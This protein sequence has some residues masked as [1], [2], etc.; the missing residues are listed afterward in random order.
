MLPLSPLITSFFVSLIP[1]FRAPAA[2]QQF[3]NSKKHSKVFINT[4]MNSLINKQLQTDEKKQ[5][6][7]VCI[8]CIFLVTSIHIN[9]LSDWTDFMHAAHTE[10]I[11]ILIDPSAPLATLWVCLFSSLSGPIR[12]KKLPLLCCVYLLAG[13]GILK[14][15]RDSFCFEIHEAGWLDKY[16]PHIDIREWPRLPALR[17]LTDIHA[18]PQ[19]L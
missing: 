8:F 2:R 3:R 15:A 11:K 19:H 12:V 5:N 4:S 16:S 14:G 18:H 1:S 7:W 10:S 6:L 13:E 17:S 9:T